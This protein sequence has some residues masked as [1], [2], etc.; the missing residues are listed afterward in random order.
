MTTTSFDWEKDT[1]EVIKLLLTRDDYLIKHQLD[2]FNDFKDRLLANIIQHY[3]PIKLNYLQQ[4]NGQFQYSIE[5]RFGDIHL[6]P[7]S[8]HENNGSLKVML[9]NEARKRSFTY[10]ANQYVDLY[11]KTMVL[12]EGTTYEIEEKCLK[13]IQFGKIPIMLHS[14]HLC[15]LSKKDNQTLKDFEECIYDRGGYFIVN[16]SEKV[17]VSQERKWE[18]KVYC[19]K[20]SKSQNK[21]SHTA[22][23]SSIGHDDFY[24][25]KTNQVKLTS[26]IGINGKTIKVSLP[27]IRHDIPLFIF[28]RLLGIESDKAILEY[29]L[30]DIECG[31]SEEFL[32]LIKPSLEEANGY[33]TRE[34]CVDYVIKYIQQVNIKDKTDKLDRS[35]KLQ[36]L[37]DILHNDFLPHM[38]KNL[39]MKSYFLGY[40]TKKMLSVYLKKLPYDDR[41]SY[42]NKK[43]DTP[44]ILM[45]NLYKL[46]FNKLIKEIKTQLNKEFNNGSWKA[47]NQFHDII[48]MS[49]IYK[50]VK[51]ITIE[52]GLKYGLS[53]GNWGIRNMQS[54]QG[55]A[56]VLSRLTYNSTLSHLRRINTPIE[57]SGKVLG[58][59]KLHSTQWGLVCVAPDT[60][61]LKD[62]GSQTTIQSL[63]RDGLGKNNIIVVNEETRKSE[64]SGIVAFQQFD[65]NEFGKKVLRLKTD[66]GRTIIAS[67]D[68]QFVRNS[69]FIACGELRVGESVLIRPTPIGI[70]EHSSSHITKLLRD[71]EAIINGPDLDDNYYNS[72]LIKSEYLRYCIYNNINGEGD[73]G[74]EYKSYLEQTN[75]DHLTGTLYSKIIE[76][77]EVSY[78]ECPIVMDL[79]TVSNV[80]TFVSN[81]FVTHNCPAETPEGHAVG[82]V[83]NMA[84]TTAVSIYSSPVSVYV[85]LENL[86]TSRL[87]ECQPD[88]I[89]NKTKIFVNGTWW[90]VHN[91]PN[92]VIKY[93][94]SLRRMGLL[95]PYTSISWRI[96]QNVVEIWTDA[97]RF[98]QPLYI[99]DN[100]EFRMNNHLIQMVKDKRLDF[101]N[102]L[103]GSLPPKIN[104][105]FPEESINVPNMSEGVI[106]YIDV[107]EKDNSLIAMTADE[108][109]TTDVNG[110]IRNYT[111]CEIHPSLILGVL[112][113]IIP[114]SDHNQSPRNI[115]QA[116]M[117]KQAMGVYCTNFSKRFDTLAHVLHYPQNP[118]VNSRLINY[119]PSS[120]LPSGI[121]AVVAIACYSGFNQDDST[122]FNQ[123]AI[124]RGLFHSTFYRSYKDE[125][126]KYQN[127]GEEEKFCK[128]NPK[129]T[130]SLKVANY[131][132]LGVNGFVPENIRVDED[133]VIIGKVIPMKNKQGQTIYKDNSTSLRP[134]ENG[135]IDKI[136]ISRNGDGYKFAKVRVRSIRIPTIGD[137]HASRSAQKGVIGMVYRQEDMPFTRNGIVPDI[138]MNPHAIPSRMTIGQLIECIMGKTCCLLGRYGD[139]TPF[140][141]FADKNLKNLMDTLQ[142]LG[143][144]R[145]GNE[146]LYNGRTGEQLSTEIFIGPTYYQRLKHMVDDKT[147]SR[148]TGPSVTLTRQPAEGRSRDGGLRIGEMER[149]VFLAHGTMGFCK[150]I[151]LDKSDHFKAFVCRKCGN[152]AIV[153]PAS[154][155]YECR[156]CNN[157]TSFTEIRLPYACKLF[158]Q[159]LNTMSIAPRM[160]TK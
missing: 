41:D 46:Y 26:K 43:L 100:N 154:K 38:G 105:D 90:G 98:L 119:L 82:C 86:K 36:L 150:E 91:N 159:E 155:K 80:H 30:N 108:L 148:P 19:F 133:D 93:L 135:Y 115:Y 139:A 17:L 111:H 34:S 7:A 28:Y 79:T 20:S 128:P 4:P 85:E 121:N 53:T 2:S 8:I 125:E 60:L 45:G 84:L 142:S 112:A 13:K 39:K 104:L 14:N 71:I 69:R 58:P 64:S 160:I 37:D 48:N 130:K 32:N 144:E 6:A 70:P 51:N 44:G 92:Q 3:N 132:K 126:K 66:T 153:N 1:W 129:L 63:V 16:G 117:G 109:H 110:Y 157:L 25:P 89:Y 78:D 62:D 52:R 31:E 22:E 149:D 120:H 74:E 101:E 65:V 50:I 146:I 42:L 76:I 18:N 47:N 9:P 77:S 127:T 140:S 12:V 113:S 106:E 87:E 124:D 143:F 107:L 158:L 138:I 10:S 81:G 95:H 33:I 97:G 15:V 54:K 103:N 23:I 156:G 35:R 73:L 67:E 147:H 61:V 99:V 56:Q 83:K 40:M 114:F 151:L 59:R 145:A 55:I 57:K 122:M 75:A 5:L 152:F 136:L 94:R 49:N 24:N 141:K 68:H 29:I 11:I 137:K 27:N 134:N 102:L 72:S 96:D 118:L 116:A 123:S 21:Y 88:D 131:E